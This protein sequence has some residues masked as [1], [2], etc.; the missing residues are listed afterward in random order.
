[1]SV[2]RALVPTMQPVLTRLAVTVV[3]VL[4]AI[5]VVNAKITLMTARHMVVT[6]M[7]PASMALAATNVNVN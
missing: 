5:M 6:T 4:L 3:I 7:V 1:M 2:R